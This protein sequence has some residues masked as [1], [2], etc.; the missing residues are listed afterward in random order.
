MLVPD[1][2]YDARIFDKISNKRKSV[3]KSSKNLD[4]EFT[5]L[6]SFDLPDKSSKKITAVKKLSKENKLKSVS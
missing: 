2:F 4:K 5:F 6:K 1:Y 3:S